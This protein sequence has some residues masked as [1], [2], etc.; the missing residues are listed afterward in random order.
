MSK[1][2][3][4][5]RKNFKRSVK[6]ASEHKGKILTVIAILIVAAVIFAYFQIGNTSANPYEI[7]KN[8]IISDKTLD[9]TKVTVFGVRLGDSQEQ[10]RNEIGNPDNEQF[11]P[12]DL[13]NWEY[14]K[15][16]DIENTGLILQ[17]KSGTLIRMTFK[18][19]F[20]KYLQGATR[21]ENTKDE[22]YGLLGAPSAIH[23]VQAN[24]ESSRAYK[25]AT[26]AP[27]NMEII[28]LA[29]KENGLSFYL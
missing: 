6:Q 16:L 2:R 9:G 20:N 1:A 3:R 29:D 8:D 15:S 7:T 12:P 13:M 21:I 23:H 27:K 18:A 28:L 25:I 11:Y 26:Y 24:K 19:P 17:F 5:I 14:G 4:A 10:V 22:V